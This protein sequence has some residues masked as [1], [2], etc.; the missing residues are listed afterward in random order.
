M[1][2]PVISRRR[3][4]YVSCILQINLGGDPNNLAID[5]IRLPRVIIPNRRESIRSARQQLQD[6]GG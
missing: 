4:A 6:L 3:F 2:P 5:D 1:E